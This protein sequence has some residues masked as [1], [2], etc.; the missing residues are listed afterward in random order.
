M[1][2]PGWPKIGCIHSV[3]AEVARASRGDAVSVAEPQVDR[4][5]T[6]WECRCLFDARANRSIRC[7]FAYV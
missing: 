7:F 1:A 6:S 2:S 3:R 4:L 5:V